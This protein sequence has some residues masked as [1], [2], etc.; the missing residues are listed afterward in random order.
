M[1]LSDLSRELLEQYYRDSL[2]INATLRSEIESVK[3]VAN[4]LAQ[5]N[6]SMKAKCDA[7]AAQVAV[8]TPL[9]RRCLWG[10]F[11]WNDHNFE[12]LHMYCR[13]SAAEVGIFTVD[14]ANAFL[15]KTPQQHLAEIRAESAL[16]SF[17]SIFGQFDFGQY[18]AKLGLLDDIE[19]LFIQYA[20]KVRQG[21]A[22]NDNK[23]ETPLERAFR[24]L[25][26]EWPEHKFSSKSYI[27][28]IVNPYSG[29]YATF[30]EPNHANLTYICTRA[31]FEQYAAKVR[32]GAE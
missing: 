28:L 32:Q 20:A 24:K 25:G 11:N 26:G 19:S 27:Y 23:T 16:K 5:E 12:P 31:E 4:D 22:Q 9:A 18:H 13:A 6:Q 3:R 29:G 30:H 14:Q 2:N 17:D 15:E 8:L 1:N 21:V 7:L 10:A